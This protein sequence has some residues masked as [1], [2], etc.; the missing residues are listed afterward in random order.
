[1]SVDFSVQSKNDG[2]M[3]IGIDT[4]WFCTNF[5]FDSVW[6]ETMQ[7]HTHTHTRE[8][9]PS[10]LS[11]YTKNW[12]IHAVEPISLFSYRIK[13]NRSL[14]SRWLLNF[15]SIRPQTG[16]STSM[17]DEI[18]CILPSLL[19]PERDEVFASGTVIDSKKM[20]VVTAAAAALLSLK[21][22]TAQL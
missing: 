3:W 12:W 1:M 2:W 4:K 11:K 13:A 15:Y 21:F 14:V 18:K 9:P 19:I 7:R 22:E 16:I 20:S 6:M 17:F 10:T 5:F 8:S